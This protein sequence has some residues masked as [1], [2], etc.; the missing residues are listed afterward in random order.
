MFDITVDDVLKVYEQLKD[1][2]DL[3]LTTTSEL[4]EG[5]SVDCPIIKPMD[6]L[7]NCTKTVVTL[8]WM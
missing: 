2:Y 8:F 6:K 3:L 7:S 1:R 5:F 4:D